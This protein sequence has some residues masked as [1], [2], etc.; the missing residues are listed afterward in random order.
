MTSDWSCT[1]VATGDDAAL[2]ELYGAIGF[3]MRYRATFPRA[4]RD[5][6]KYWWPI[7]TGQVEMADGRLALAFACRRTHPFAFA[8]ELAARHPRVRIVCTAIELQ[9][10]IAC[11]L[12]LV[13]RRVEREDEVDFAQHLPRGDRNAAIA[14]WEAWNRGLDWPA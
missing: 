9:L 4:W 12:V 5:C 2:A 1:L 13:G 11:R 7:L 14:L 6:P 10:E 3:I 8:R